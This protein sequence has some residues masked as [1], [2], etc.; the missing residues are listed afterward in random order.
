MDLS[1][2]LAGVVLLLVLMSIKGNSESNQY[3]EVPAAAV[4]ES[5][6]RDAELQDQE[7]EH[8]VSLN[9]AERLQRVANIQRLQTDKSQIQAEIVSVHDL[10]V[11]FDG[12][13]A[14]DIDHFAVPHYMLQVIIGP[15]GAGKTTLC[16]VISG[17]TRPTTGRVL[18]NGEDITEASEAD[19]ARLGVGRK[20]QTPTVYSPDARTGPTG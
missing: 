19:I 6:E 15:N 18:F 2:L 11:V 13:K 17:K 4:P 8:V 20:F 9:M 14:L 16:D 7:S 12:F 3:G 10:T 1:Y 5:A